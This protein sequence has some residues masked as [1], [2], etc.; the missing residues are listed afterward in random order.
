MS[1][2][3]IQDW[4]LWSLF[5]DLIKMS[6]RDNSERSIPR[7]SYDGSQRSAQ[8]VP[9]RAFSRTI[10]V[11]D[12][13]DVA[14][15][16]H[17]RASRV[18]Q[19][20]QPDQGDPYDINSRRAQAVPGS[21]FSRTIAVEDPSNVSP[22]TRHR[23]SRVVLSE[24][25]DIAAAFPAGRGPELPR[26]EPMILPQPR[27]QGRGYIGQMTPSSRITSEP[28]DS[29]RIS[30]LISEE[31]GIAFETALP[32]GELLDGSRV[33][34]GYSPRVWFGVKAYRR[35]CPCSDA[36]KRRKGALVN[37]SQPARFASRITGE[38][39]IITRELLGLF[40]GGMDPYVRQPLIAKVS[41]DDIDGALD[42]LAARKECDV[43]KLLYRGEDYFQGQN[44]LE[45]GFAY[46]G[47]SMNNDF[48]P[49]LYATPDLEVA[50]NYAARGRQEREV[51][52]LYV[53]DWSDDGGVDLVP[54]TEALYGPRWKLFVK[55]NV[56]LCELPEEAL[57]LYTQAEFVEKSVFQGPISANHSDIER[58]H[59]PLASLYT[60][61]CFKDQLSRAALIERL[62]G[63]IMVEYA[64]D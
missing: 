6:R 34:F 30:Q 2:Y 45:T 10:A 59:E 18:V 47:S 16:D 33:M 27:V 8:A 35:G 38:F 22:E 31:L 13:G 12:P 51:G 29:L 19:A 23:A 64:A 17:Y 44:H 11:E 54:R 5:Y 20:E 24:Q 53:F 41:L 58:C 55:R 15:G 52:W 3:K 62:I 37:R 28:Y 50:L 40:A 36:W 32:Y 63:L 4:S 42:L 48:G 7:D 39:Q 46:M 60:Q 49:G 56:S 43:S 1:R 25:E 9:G 57:N 61:L 21:A 26:Q 14:P